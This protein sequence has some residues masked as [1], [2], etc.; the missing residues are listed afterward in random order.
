[1]AYAARPDVEFEVQ[2]RHADRDTFEEA[3]AWNQRVE[4]MA[5]VAARNERGE[6][7]FI[8][9]QDYGGWTTPGGRVDDGESFRDGAVRE[10]HE[11]SGVEVAICRPLFVFQFV[12]RHEGQST[13]TFLVLFEAKATDPVPAENPGVGDETIRD[14]QWTDTV[15]ARLPDDEFVRSTVRRLAREFDT[16]D[17]A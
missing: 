5:G 16:V 7:L 15:P 10:C 12:N 17:L 6:M 14:V 4:G 1:M 9:H 8:D 13:D 2:I 11:E 3:R